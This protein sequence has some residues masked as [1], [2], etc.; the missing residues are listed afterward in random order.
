MDGVTKQDHILAESILDDGRP[1][2]IL[3]NKWNSRPG[4]PPAPGNLKDYESLKEF[5]RVYEESI[6]NELFFLPDSPHPVCVGQDR[7]LH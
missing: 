6:R 2:A 3:V 5:M 7:F 4:N 1:L